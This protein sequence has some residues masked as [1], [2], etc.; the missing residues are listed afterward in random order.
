MA[1]ARKHM[2]FMYHTVYNAHRLYY[3]Q[4]VFAQY[5]WKKKEKKKERHGSWCVF[6]FHNA[7]FKR[8]HGCGQKIYALYVS[9]H[10]PCPTTNT[11][12]TRGGLT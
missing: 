9:H 8:G 6:A 10:V 11:L 1:A 12:G 7:L 4:N 5:A 2:H 3:A